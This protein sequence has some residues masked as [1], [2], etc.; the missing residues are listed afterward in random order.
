MRTKHMATQ[1]IS[2]FISR[3]DNLAETIRLPHSDS[4][5]ICPEEGLEAS[6]RYTGSL[7]V[8]FSHSHA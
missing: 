7:A 4:L 5:A 3:Y 8:L 2:W 1:D 6:D